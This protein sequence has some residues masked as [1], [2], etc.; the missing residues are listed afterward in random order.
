M[1]KEKEIQKGQETGRGKR[2]GEI[3]ENEN[4]KYYLCK[5]EISK[6][7]KAHMS[8]VTTEWKQ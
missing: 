6:Q 2:G 7:I 3:I 8:L 5:K 1:F 4:V